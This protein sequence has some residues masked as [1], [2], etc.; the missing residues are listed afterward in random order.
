MADVSVRRHRRRWEDLPD[1]SGWRYNDRSMPKSL[2]TGV[3][4][5]IGSHLA[6]AL[7]KEGH[8]V[9]GIDCFADF[10]PRAVKEANLQPALANP[11]FKF[12]EADLFDMDIGPAL[13]DAD[14]VFHQAAQPGVRGSWGTTFEV[15]VRQNILSTQRLLEAVKAIP[16]E[17]FVYASSSSVYGDAESPVT[18]E[19]APLRPLSPYG[20]TKLAAE[21]LC[22]SYALNFGIPVVSLRYF[23]VYG[24]RQRPDMGFHRF[25]R[26][27]LERQPVTVFG[28]GSQA[29]DFTFVQDVVRAN[30]LA[31]RSP[32]RNDVFN[33]SG[34]GATTV[35]A[36]LRLIG[37]LTGR[38]PV[39]R[40]AEPLKGEARRTGADL[41]KAN[42]LLGYQ[43][44][45]TLR[46]GLQSQIEWLRSRTPT[47]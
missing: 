34:G 18:S 16:L 13:R 4:G 28:D 29:R 33:V 23:S 20:V 10:Y 47:I 30:L 26:A 46:E 32:F 3:A 40:Y 37:E 14:Y 43:P 8:H 31:I 27:A 45:H 35:N 19:T 11:H 2:V 1:P 22:H 12:I 15:Y 42:S 5:F 21:N 17:K 44:A 7:L 38:E 41:S 9:A 6:E 25:I 36:I 39:L 24:P